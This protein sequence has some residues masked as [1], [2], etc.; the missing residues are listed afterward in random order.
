[1]DRIQG[2]GKMTEDAC[3][4]AYDFIGFP[5]KDIIASLSHPS[6]TNFLA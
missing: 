1:M 2:F 4:R 5:S 3:K 6:I